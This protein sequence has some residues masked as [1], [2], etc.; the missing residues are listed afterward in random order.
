[1]GRKMMKE[2][3]EKSVVVVTIVAIMRY[4]CNMIPHLMCLTAAVMMM[5]KK[6][7]RKKRNTQEII[8]YLTVVFVNRMIWIRNKK[9]I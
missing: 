2:M 9:S 1:M 4:Q 6:R 7:R 5:G 3:T 8:D